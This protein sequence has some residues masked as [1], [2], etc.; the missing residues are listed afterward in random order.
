MPCQN[1]SLSFFIFF[2]LFL[3]FYF[4]A[5]ITFYYCPLY[6]IILMLTCH[7]DISF[8]SIEISGLLFTFTDNKIHIYTYVVPLFDELVLFCLHGD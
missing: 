7:T 1:L 6:Y 8:S 3:F 2:Y 4:I 5:F